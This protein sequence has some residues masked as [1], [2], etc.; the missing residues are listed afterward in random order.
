AK[1]TPEQREPLEKKIA[2]RWDAVK[3]GGNADDLRKFVGTFGMQFKVGREARLALAEQ[4]MDENTKDNLLEAER[5]LL[6]LRQQQDDPQ[7]AGTAVETLAR[8]MARK[9]LLEDAAHYYRVLARDFAKVQ[10][11]EGKT[12]DDIFNELATDKRFLPYLDEPTA[13]W[14]ASNIKVKEEN[15]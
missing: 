15:G 11:R 7:T 8:L 9:G 2:E 1:A 14:G 3:K 10:V 13:A 6:L 12:G 5:Q 4:L